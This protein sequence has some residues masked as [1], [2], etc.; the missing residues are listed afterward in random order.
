MNPERSILLQARRGLSFRATVLLLLGVALL[1]ALVFFV[2]EPRRDELIQLRDAGFAIL[3]VGGLLLLLLFAGGLL[4]WLSQPVGLAFENATGEPEFDGAFVAQAVAGELQQIVSVHAAGSPQAR[5]EATTATFVS[6]QPAV[7]SRR[8]IMAAAVRAPLAPSGRAD[9]VA[10]IGTVDIAGTSLPLGSMLMAVKQLWPL[11]KAGV[12]ITGRLCRN[13]GSL[14]LSVHLRRPRRAGKSFVARGSD[15]TEVVTAAAV[16]IAYELS[17]GYRGVSR[18]GFDGLTRAMEHYQEFHQTQSPEEFAAAVSAVGRIPVADDRNTYIRGLLYNLGISCLG[19]GDL[20]LAEK[21]LT[22]AHCAVATDASVC[23]ALGMVYFEQHRF[24]EA[25]ETF[26]LAT[27]L[28]PAIARTRALKAEWD[29][30]AWNGLGNTYVEL[31]DY[32]GAIQ[33]YQRA[34]DL[35]RKVATPHTGLGNAYLQQHRWAAAEREYRV[36][37]ALDPRAAHPWHGLGN[38]Q[39]RRGRFGEA[40]DHHRTAL[41][42]DA[43]FAEAWNGLGEAYAALGRFDEAIAAHE[44]ALTLRKDEPYTLASLGET[45][46]KQGDLH[47]AREVLERALDED[48]SASYVWRGLGFLLLRT[49]EPREAARAF[50]QAVR[51]NPRDAA[52]WDGRAEA[53]RALDDGSG[54]E[55]ESL[56]VAADENPEEPWAWNRLGDAYFRAGA[57]A[58]SRDAHGEALWLDPANSY[59][60]DGMGKAYLAL[61]DL[62]SAR[63]AHEEALAI[64]PEDAYAPHGIANVLMAAGD[65]GGAAA[66]NRAA[67]RIDGGALFARNG[68]G[69]ACERM[70]DYDEAAGH[71]RR[72]VETA[73]EDVAAAAYAHDGLARIA[74][75]QRRPADALTAVRAARDLQPRQVYPLVTLGDVHLGQRACEEAVEAYRQALV[76]DPKLVAAGDGLGRAYVWRGNYA[77]AEETYRQ[78]IES[79]GDDWR[80]LTGAADVLLRGAIAERRDDAYEEIVK[81]YDAVLQQEP[82]LAVAAR[83]RLAA[84][85]AV[86]GD[87]DTAVVQADAVVRDFAVC[88]ARR[89]YPDHDLLEIRALALLLSG[90]AAGALK[91]I[92]EARAGLLAGGQLD[93]VRAG[94]YELL[95]EERVPGFQEFAAVVREQQAG[96]EPSDV[97]ASD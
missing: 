29:I 31:A 10:A 34:I 53:A 62:D 55:L 7:L 71:Y 45:Y 60:Y 6:L 92:S 28:R 86:R 37:I 35:Q 13:E 41:R 96:R 23:T 93:A 18:P 54:V 81:R 56:Q 72:V 39:T 47:R 85:A 49:Q 15:L 38:L 65:F 51:R 12:V 76:A 87:R 26:L 91:Q 20:M 32:T 46:L 27:S 44:K 69:D 21:L 84:I 88:W 17:P 30:A 67:L 22:R 95:T 24:A 1:A 97:H 78:A 8:E 19:G 50:D 40:L 59:A 42:L 11:P 25:K 48:P 89:P 73:G 94:V 14:L 82:V 4:V 74:L 64:N 75:A 52:A 79:C 36:A 9:A 3:Q 63:E 77:T 43:G 80:L 66:Q 70:R 5:R 57:Y 16:R 61:G 83:I 90:D 33:A 68:L 58:D 2:E